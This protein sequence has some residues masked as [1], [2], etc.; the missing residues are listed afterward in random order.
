MHIRQLQLTADNT[1]FAPFYPRRNEAW[2]RPRGY[3]RINT[4]EFCFYRD[5]AL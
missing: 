4:R 2:Q 1:A 3:A 5:T